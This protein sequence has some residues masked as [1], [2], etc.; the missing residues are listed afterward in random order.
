MNTHRLAAVL[1]MLGVA[2]LTMTACSAE[3][4]ADELAEEVERTLTAEFGVELDAV[5][6]PDALP[7]EEGSEV[8]CTLTF[9][10]EDYG[11]TVTSEGEEDDQVNFVIEVDDEPT[12]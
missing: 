2:A 1:P 11:A 9:E 4:P 12:G 5:E 6:C 8:R 10:G 3:V 7:A